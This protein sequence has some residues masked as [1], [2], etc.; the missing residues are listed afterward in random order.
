MKKYGFGFV[1]DGKPETFNKFWRRLG[2]AVQNSY[3][4]DPSKYKVKVETR[5]WEKRGWPKID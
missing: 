5:V 4:Q 1:W 2:Q 3:N